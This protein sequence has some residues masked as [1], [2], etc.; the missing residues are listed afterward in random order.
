MSNQFFR[1]RHAT[2]LH[3]SLSFLYLQD[4]Y[5]FVRKEPSYIALVCLLAASLLFNQV[6]INFFHGKHDAHEVQQKQ[7]DQAQLHKHGDHCKVCALDTLFNLF[8]EPSGDFGFHQSNEVWLA[9]YAVNAK[10]V[11]IL[12]S[13]DRAPPVS[14]S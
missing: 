13:Q 14:I 3:K 6:G 11:G 4:R 1:P 5:E 2:L 10:L 8:F 9:F 12:L 7:T